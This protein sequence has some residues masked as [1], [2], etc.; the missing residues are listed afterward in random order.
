MSLEDKVAAI[1]ASGSGAAPKWAEMITAILVPLTG[2]MMA[3]T[4]I[5]IGCKKLGVE[6]ENLSRQHLKPLSEHIG[7]ALAL[8]VGEDKAGEVA[9]I[10][11][12]L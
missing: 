11:A 12:S 8:F 3:K 1:L 6:P 5:A 4:T 7:K 2:Q 10:I 9:S